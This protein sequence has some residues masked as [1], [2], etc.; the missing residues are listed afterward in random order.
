MDP[1][2]CIKFRCEN[3]AFSQSVMG[4]T[5]SYEWCKRFDEHREDGKD[6]ECPGLLS[7]STTNHRVEK[8]MKM[9]MDDCRIIVIT[10]TDNI[11][12]SV[13]S[14][15]ANSLDFFDVKRVAAK[16]TPELLNFEQ[17]PP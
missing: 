13:G 1:N 7:I 11:D 14:W 12:I 3:V 4:K 9:I 15:L 8:V 6:N 5:R 10:V 17:K 2:I 16:F